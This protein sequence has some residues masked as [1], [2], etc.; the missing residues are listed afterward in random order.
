MKEKSVLFH[1]PDRKTYAGFEHEGHIENWP[2]ESTG[3]REYASHLFYDHSGKAPSETALNAAFQTL[4]GIAK[5]EGEEH[6]VY[7][8]CAQYE[9]GYVSDLCN[10][11]WSVVLV[12]PRGWQVVNES[13][14][15]FYRTDNMRP[16]PVPAESGNIGKL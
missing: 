9:D 6:S 11:S 1:D 13:P 5:Y 14:V 3:F 8:R 2:I 7:L 12:T 16:L 4:S 15:K 10:E